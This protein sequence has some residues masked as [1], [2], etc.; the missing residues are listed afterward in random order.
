MKCHIHFTKTP[1]IKYTLIIVGTSMIIYGFVKD[2]DLVTFIGIAMLC[3]VLF[4][5]NIKVG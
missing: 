2:V 1:L 5:N 3:V 4:L